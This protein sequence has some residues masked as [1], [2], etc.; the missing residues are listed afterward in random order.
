MNKYNYLL[1]AVLYCE[2]ISISQNYLFP[3]PSQKIQKYMVTI[4]QITE[5]KHHKSTH[6]HPNSPI[7]RRLSS[8]IMYYRKL[9]QQ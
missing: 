3:S 8:I 6:R 4:H 1:E 2:E 7:I 9:L 5:S